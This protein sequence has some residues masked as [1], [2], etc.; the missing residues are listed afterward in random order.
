MAVD[1]SR[2]STE[3]NR[4]KRRIGTASKR[5]NRKALFSTSYTKHQ[6]VH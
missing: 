1:I 2:G 4:R 6:I 5:S 3:V